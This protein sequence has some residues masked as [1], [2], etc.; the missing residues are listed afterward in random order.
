LAQQSATVRDL[1]TGVQELV[2]LDALNE[3]LARFS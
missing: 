3:R 1:E 2:S